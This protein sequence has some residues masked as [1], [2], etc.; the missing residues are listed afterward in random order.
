VPRFVDWPVA[1]MAAAIKS[2][3]ISMFVRII[4]LDV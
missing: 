3:S 1:C 2:S 4:S